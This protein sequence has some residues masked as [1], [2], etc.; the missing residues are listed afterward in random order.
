M[1]STGIKQAKSGHDLRRT[2]S[3]SLIERDSKCFRAILNFK[4]VPE[5]FDASG[6]SQLCCLH[7][8]RNESTIRANEIELQMLEQ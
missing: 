4:R 1:N 5:L 8:R 6:T 2:G 3:Y 7:L